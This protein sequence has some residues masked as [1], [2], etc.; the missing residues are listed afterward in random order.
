MLDLDFITLRPEALTLD[1]AVGRN[2]LT[3]DEH[4]IW[5]QLPPRARER[6]ISV[7]EMFLRTTYLLPVNWTTLDEKSKS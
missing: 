5:I 1:S 3:D 6:K 7:E 2:A 4:D